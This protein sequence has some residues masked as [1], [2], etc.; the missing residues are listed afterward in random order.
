MKTEEKRQTILDIAASAFQELGFERTSMSEICQR[1][2]GSKA[3]IYNYFASKEELFSEVMFQ[4]TEAEF[5]VVHNALDQ[6]IGDIAES[7]RRFGERFLEFLYSPRI[8][9][10][11]HLAISESRRTE[12]GRLVYERG[13]ERSQALIAGFLS[14]AAS[15][16][17]LG[18]TD[19]GGSGDFDPVIAARQFCSLLEAE[20][21][22]PFLYHQINSVTP[23][24]IQAG[25]AR[26][27]SL[28][29]AGY[30][31]RD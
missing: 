31:P 27:V 10:E 22:D 13:V 6:N 5:V 19:P 12:L 30:G 1:V 15:A 11:R 4:S 8:M 26:A 29:M 17:K 21:L 18:R 28:F 9:A 2:G 23:G 3:T 16:G 25:T 20:F 24:Q 7:L 14:T